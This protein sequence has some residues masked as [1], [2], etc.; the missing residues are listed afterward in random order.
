MRG[1]ASTTTSSLGA[2]HAGRCGRR[3]GRAAPPGRAPARVHRHHPRHDPVTP[4]RVGSL[5]HRHLRHAGMAGQDL[6]DLGRPHLLA[7]GDDH[8]GHPAVHDERAVGLQTAGIPGREPAAGQPRVGAVAVAA[9]Q[10]RAPYQDLALRSLTA[11]TDP[12]FHAVERTSV[13]DAAGA[14]LGE[15]V[16]RDHAG[17]QEAAGRPRRAAR[18]GS[19]RRR[20][21]R[22]RWRRGRPGWRRPGPRPR[23]HGGSNRRRTVQGVPVTSERVTTER[24]PMWASGRQATQRSRQGST[25]RPAEVARADASTDAWVWT[26]PLGSPVVPLVATTRA[27]PGSVGRPPGRV[28]DPPA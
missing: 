16:G 26:T 24:P 4:L 12:E 28:Q 14:R 2:A 7:P 23:R 27:S 21:A 13:V 5:P 10:H 20:S 25:P 17:R 11:V 9:Q 15:A 18:R 19:P 1:S 6:L 22:G 3:P 8:L